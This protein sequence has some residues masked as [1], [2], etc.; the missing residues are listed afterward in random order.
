MEM[1]LLLLQGGFE[2][3]SVL[4]VVQWFAFQVIHLCKGLSML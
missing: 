2:M 4:L 3:C 1:L